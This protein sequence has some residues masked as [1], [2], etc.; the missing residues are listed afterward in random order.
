[1]RADS[2]LRVITKSKDLLKLTFRIFEN[3]PKKFR[4]TLTTRIINL[5]MDVLESLVL[6]NEVL[7]SA[8]SFGTERRLNYQKR[9]IAKLKIIDTLLLVAREQRCILPKQH[10]SLS[11]LV[12][13]CQNMTGAWIVSDRNRLMNMGIRL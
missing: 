4:F 7:L 3:S 13:D 6:A 1:M 10:E 9:A 11:K 2:E 12:S 8:D 5:S